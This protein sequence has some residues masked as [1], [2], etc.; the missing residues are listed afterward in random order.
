LFHPQANGNS[1]TPQEAKI[2]AEELAE[3]I[4]VLERLKKRLEEELDFMLKISSQGGVG[5]E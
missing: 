4:R 1:I 5:Q 3:E 2:K